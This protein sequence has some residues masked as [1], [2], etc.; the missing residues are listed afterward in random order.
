MGSC[1]AASLLFRYHLHINVAK[2]LVQKVINVEATVII[3]ICFV[4]SLLPLVCYPIFSG[5][6]I[7]KSGCNK[8][9]S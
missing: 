9:A 1:K 8:A 2:E 5:D 7:L 4:F 3:D 6:I